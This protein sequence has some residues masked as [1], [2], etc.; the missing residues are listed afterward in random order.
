MV[1]TGSQCAL[2]VVLYLYTILSVKVM[3][4]AEIRKQVDGTLPHHL[5]FRD[6]GRTDERLQQMNR[7]NADD[8]HRQFDFQI[9]T[10]V[11]RLAI[12][13]TSIRLSTA[14]MTVFY[15]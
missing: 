11:S 1:S 10:I 12:I 15:P 3:A 6:I 7:Q 5:L 8:G 4:M 14:S 13:T 9:I 2:C